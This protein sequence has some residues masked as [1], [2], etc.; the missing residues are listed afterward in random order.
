MG[1][2]IPNAFVI[3]DSLGCLIDA[4]RPGAPIVW[5]GLLQIQ[6]YPVI[7]TI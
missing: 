7:Q 2:V 6:E 1:N 4:S 5:N 3:H